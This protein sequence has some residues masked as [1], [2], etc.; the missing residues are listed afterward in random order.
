MCI[1][2]TKLL[3]EH[4]IC[5]CF[6]HYALRK[7]RDEFKENKNVTD[8]QKVTELLK[9]AQSNLEIIKR[10]VSDV[11]LVLNGLIMSPPTMVL[12]HCFWPVLCPFV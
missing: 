5:I 11:L 8:T 2:I 12:G 6:R 10:Q 3:H 1:R 9:K 4:F 7:T